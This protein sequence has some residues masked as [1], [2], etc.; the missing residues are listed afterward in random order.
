[1]SDELDTYSFLP[2][3]RLGVA[4]NIYV[5]I[6]MVLL[7]GLATKNAILIVEF[8]KV[9]RE[10]GDSIL[11][12]AVTAARLRFRAVIMTAF[13]FILGIIPLLLATGAGAVSRQSLGTTVFSGML[14]AGIVGTL[15]VPTFFVAIRWAAEK[16][17]KQS[18]EAD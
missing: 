2:W 13:S 8:A 5:Q 18:P 6:G 9:R 11:D 15:F 3:L 1:M 10:N 12:A 4:N 16:L 14:M 7:I 17:S